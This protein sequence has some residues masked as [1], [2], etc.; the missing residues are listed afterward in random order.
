MTPRQVL[1][2]LDAQWAADWPGFRMLSVTEYLAMRLIVVHDGSDWGLI[3]DQVN[4]SFIDDDNENA[5]GV[6]SKIYGPSV[7]DY[8]IN[9]PVKRPL[10][11][12]ATPPVPEDLVLEGVRVFGPAGVLEL[13]ADSVQRLDLR[14][15]KVANFDGISERPADLLILRAYLTRYSGSLFGPVA[16]ALPT[17]GASENDV[18]LVTDAF[19]HVLSGPAEGEPDARYAKRP[20]ESAVFQSIAEAIATRDASR[21]LA[22]NSNLDWRLW[23]NIDDERVLRP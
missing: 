10:G 20:S 4:G 22:G 6:R 1:D 17:L 19:E 3:F 2:V 5:A 18:L 16:D 23:A 21:F 7:P 15:G 13:D 9:V 8:H 11:L 14:P 12:S